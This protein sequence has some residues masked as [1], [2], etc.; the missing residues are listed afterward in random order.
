[1]SKG[2]LCITKTSALAIGQYSLASTHNDAF[3]FMKLLPDALMSLI[4]KALHPLP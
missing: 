4:S 1:M 3:T 2:P